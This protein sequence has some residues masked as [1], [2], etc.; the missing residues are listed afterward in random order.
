VA[1]SFSVPARNRVR[2]RALV[3]IDDVMTTGATLAACARVLLD[4]GAV[5]VRV[6]SLARALAPNS[7]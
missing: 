2:G 1:E 3:V 5:E 6:A 4:A 7:P